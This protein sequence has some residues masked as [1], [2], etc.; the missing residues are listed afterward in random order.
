[1]K[2]NK[3]EGVVKRVKGVLNAWRSSGF[4]K[5]RVQQISLTDR[6]E[7]IV[8]VDTLQGDTEADARWKAVTYV[9][10]PGLR[11]AIIEAIPQHE[12]WQ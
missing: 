10:V 2:T 1:M 11:E 12:R 3:I 8:I 9:A 7:D 6:L 4:N 5:F